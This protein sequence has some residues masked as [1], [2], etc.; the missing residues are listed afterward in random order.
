MCLS[1]ESWKYRKGKQEQEPG[2]VDE[3]RNAERC[4]REPILPHPQDLGEQAYSVGCLSSCPFKFVIEARVFKLGKIKRGGM[5]HQQDAGAIGDEIAEKALD[6]RR[7]SG[8]KLPRDDDANLER[9][10]LPQSSWVGGRSS[11][12]DNSVNNELADPEGRDRCDRTNEP[13]PDGCAKEPGVGLPNQTE[14]WWD[15]AKRLDLFTKPWLAIT[16][17]L[18]GPW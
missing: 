18:T 12:C 2:I 6:Q 16:V 14:V 17:V 3:Q 13:Q 10:E 4:E 7:S 5:F 1:E 8:E 9:Y 15:E 11:H